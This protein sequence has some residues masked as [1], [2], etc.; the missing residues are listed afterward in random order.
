MYDQ[1]L[2]EMGNIYESLLESQPL[3]EVESATFDFQAVKSSGRKLSGSYY[4]PSS[5]VESLLI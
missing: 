3:V 5:L 4:T 1:K 2:R